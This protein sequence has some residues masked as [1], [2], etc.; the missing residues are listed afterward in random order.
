VA[1]LAVGFGVG[2]SAGLEGGFFGLLFFGSSLGLFL[3][4]HRPPAIAVAVAVIFSNSLERGLAGWANARPKAGG[5][6]A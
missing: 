6:E 2:L 5:I 4:C 1:A 3:L